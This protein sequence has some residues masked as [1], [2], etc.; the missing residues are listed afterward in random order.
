[1]AAT[2]LGRTSQGFRADLYGRLRRGYDDSPLI[3][4]GN[5][6]PAG[7]VTVP[8]HG[9][10]FDTRW[11]SVTSGGGAAGT[12]TTWRRWRPTSAAQR[13]GEAAE[14]TGVAFGLGD[15]SAHPSVDAGIGH[16]LPNRGAPEVDEQI[17][18]VQQPVFLMQAI[19]VEAEQISVGGNL[20]RPR[21]RPRAIHILARPDR[22]FQCQRLR[23][24]DW[25]PYMAFRSPL[26][27]STCFRDVRRK[28]FRIT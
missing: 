4:T 1:M 7:G 25:V 6:V 2:R 26:S 22:F 10:T 17:F 13:P 8:Q 20:S 15:R 12:S 27:A 21:L 16:R 24:P 23:R 28:E 3:V 5:L 18:A 9:P 19:A 14:L 11:Y